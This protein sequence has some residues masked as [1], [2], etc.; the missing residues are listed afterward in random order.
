M[1]YVGQQQSSISC[2][3]QFEIDGAMVGVMV[4]ASVKGVTHLIEISESATPSV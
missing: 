3:V 4:G 1:L 2:A